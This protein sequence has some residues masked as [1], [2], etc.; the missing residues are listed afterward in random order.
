MIS[1]MD[2]DYAQVLTVLTT[3]SNGKPIKQAKSPWQC[4]LENA[5]MLGLSRESLVNVSPPDHAIAQMVAMLLNTLPKEKKI[6]IERLNVL[7]AAVHNSQLSQ[8]LSIVPNIIAAVILARSVYIHLVCS[9][10][11][12]CSF[13]IQSHQ[14]SGQRQSTAPSRFSRTGWPPL[15]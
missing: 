15:S 8:E 13:F 9:N 10:V 1:P 5:S 2:Q 12:P 11:K 3:L 14:G 7:S 4:V 6:L